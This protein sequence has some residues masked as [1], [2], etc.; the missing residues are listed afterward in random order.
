MLI[1]NTTRGLEIKCIIPDLVVTLG[2]GARFAVV[3]TK[4]I[5]KGC[6][7]ALFFFATR[8]IGCFNYFFFVTKVAAWNVQTRR[9]TENKLTSQLSRNFHQKY[10]PLPPLSSLPVGGTQRL[11]STV[12]TAWSPLTWARP[13]CTSVQRL[14]SSLS[15][16]WLWQW[17]EDAELERYLLFDIVTNVSRLWG[18]FMQG[19]GT[20]RIASAAEWYKSALDNSDEHDDYDHH[21]NDDK[22]VDKNQICTK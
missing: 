11:S 22:A 18:W 13:G 12:I 2:P 7:Y 5:E 17:E 14:P 8:L 19:L 4:Q 20:C 3:I 9:E 10:L 16:W 15:T 1:Y 6:G 21:H